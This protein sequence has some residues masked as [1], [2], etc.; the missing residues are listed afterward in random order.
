LSGRNFADVLESHLT[1]YLGRCAAWVQASEPWATIA[2]AVKQDPAPAVARVLGAW[3]AED[4]ATQGAPVGA[5]Q[6]QEMRARSQQVERALM[7]ALAAV[8][9]RLKEAG[10]MASSAEAAENLAELLGGE[11]DQLA[12]AVQH[13]FLRAAGAPMVALRRGITLEDVVP[14]GSR[15][16]RV[17]FSRPLAPPPGLALEPLAHLR[18]DVARL[19]HYAMRDTVARA[20]RPMSV[21]ESSSFFKVVRPAVPFEGDLGQFKT[22]SGLANAADLWADEVRAGMFVGFEDRLKARSASALL[23][24]SQEVRSILRA[25]EMERAVADLNGAL[26]H[27]PEAAAIP[28]EGLLALVIAAPLPTGG[29]TL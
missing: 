15:G 6:A 18:Q 10:P 8:A 28:A 29:L 20:F 3:L 4:M 19:K 24:P 22:L 7:E 26:E 13:G 9:A 12:D 16:E 21:V 25:L 23:G 1:A 14:E 17:R 27:E 11:S 2:G 5:A